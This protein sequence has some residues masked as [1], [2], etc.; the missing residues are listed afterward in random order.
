MTAIARAILKS[1]KFLCCDESTSSLDSTTEKEIM[2]SIE[3]LFGKTTSIMIAHRLSTIQRADQIIVLNN[4]GSVAEAGAHSELITKESGI[5][6]EM[7]KRQV[8]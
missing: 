6:A 2:K 5:Y 1:P 3:E 7:W 8:H 4:R